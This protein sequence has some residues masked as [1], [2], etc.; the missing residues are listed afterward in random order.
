MI[1]NQ[2]NR[3]KMFK[4]A[5]VDNLE[6]ARKMPYTQKYINRIL[7][8]CAFTICVKGLCEHLSDETVLS[9]ARL[10]VVNHLLKYL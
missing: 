9:Q 4:K 2:K 5:W 6:S 10:T 8:F 7:E 3:F 1:P